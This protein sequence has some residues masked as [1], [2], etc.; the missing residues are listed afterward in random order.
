MAIP[1]YI[2]FLILGVIAFAIS[3]FLSLKK[4]KKLKYENYELFKA[5]SKVLLKNKEERHIR[6]G[7]ATKK[8]YEQK[9]ALKC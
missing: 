9:K 1:S 3:L 8:K 7:M 5:V 2:A 4:Y 6:G